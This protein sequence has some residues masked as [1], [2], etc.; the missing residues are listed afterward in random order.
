MVSTSLTEKVKSVN[1][2]VGDYV[3][4]GD[5]ICTLDDGDITKEIEK[6]N[7]K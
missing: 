6:K 2:K 4:A 3:K 5:V 7:L 1:V